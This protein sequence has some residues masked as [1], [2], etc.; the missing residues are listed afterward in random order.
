MNTIEDQLVNEIYE[1]MSRQS[2]YNFYTSEADDS[3]TAHIQCND[4]CP[5]K[6]EILKEIKSLFQPLIKKVTTPPTGV[7]KI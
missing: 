5:T 3:F 1:I 4:N 2:F 7:G 6:E